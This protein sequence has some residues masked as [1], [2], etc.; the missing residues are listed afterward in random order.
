[1]TA[2]D[3]IVALFLLWIL[4]YGVLPG[5]EV[6][7][8]CNFCMENSEEEA[9]ISSACIMINSHAYIVTMSIPT[10]K[11]MLDSLCYI[12]HNG[13]RYS[14]DSTASPVLK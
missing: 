12:A 5:L 3:V 2:G 14:P 11:G 9:H 6:L 4:G 7:P 10:T 1:M 8:M 13:L